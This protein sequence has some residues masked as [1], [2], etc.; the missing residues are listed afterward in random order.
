MIQADPMPV[1]VNF[2]GDKPFTNHEIKLDMGDTFYIFSDGFVDQIGGGENKRF[3]S[4]RFKK[5][6]LDIN[7]QAMYEQ[8]EALER[9]LKEWMADHP[10]RDD[11]LV[12]GVRV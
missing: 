1:G 5:M 2:S 12:I 6:L 9:T 4:N 10:Q 8:K 11:I 3:R 7:D